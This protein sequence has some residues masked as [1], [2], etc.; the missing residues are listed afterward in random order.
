MAST[1]ARTHHYAPCRTSL[2]TLFGLTALRD[3]GVR[4]HT[5]TTLAK[6][7]ALTT[8]PPALIA[9]ISTLVIGNHLLLAKL[10]NEFLRVQGGN[11]PSAR[12]AACRGHSE[13]RH[14][15]KTTPCQIS[16]PHGRSH[17]LALRRISWHLHTEVDILMALPVGCLYTTPLH[18]PPVSGLRARR[19]FERC[20]SVDGRDDDASAKD[21]L[22]ERELHLVHGRQQGSGWHRMCA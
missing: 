12:W 22:G 11:S 21:C 9:P 16:A 18:H 13:S 1:L 19:H 8:R 2:E 6:A 15:M 20:F 14:V 7:P 17:L 4:G 3:D 10:R 5:R